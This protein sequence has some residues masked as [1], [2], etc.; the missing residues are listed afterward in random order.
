MRYDVKKMREDLKQRAAR[1]RELKALRR[2]SHQPRWTWREQDEFG[3]L[4]EETTVL[5]VLRASWRCRLHV[6]AEHK[7][8]KTWS[9]K[10]ARLSAGY[11]LS[12]VPYV[13]EET[14]TA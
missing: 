5:C 1:L 9:E 4:K 14:L 8:A 10:A 3:R 2:E 13:S 12:E 7:M 6:P 11:E